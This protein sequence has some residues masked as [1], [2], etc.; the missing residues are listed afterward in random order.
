MKEW[1]TAGRENPGYPYA[2]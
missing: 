2:G 1:A